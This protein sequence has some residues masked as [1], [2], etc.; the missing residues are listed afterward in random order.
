MS[1]IRMYYYYRDAPHTVYNLGVHKIFL[2]LIL[3]LSSHSKQK[4]ILYYF[5]R[6]K[7]VPRFISRKQSLEWKAQG[8]LHHIMV[9]STDRA[10]SR[11]A[12]SPSTNNT[13]QFFIVLI[14]LLNSNFS[15]RQ[16]LP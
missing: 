14:I 16:L 12:K 2:W 1:Q 9:C 5:F 4:R 11:V 10:W 15:P 6:E 7:G 13:R 8:L 3:T